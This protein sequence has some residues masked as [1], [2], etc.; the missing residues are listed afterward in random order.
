MHRYSVPGM[1][2][3]HCAGTIDQAIKAIDPRAQVTIDIKSKH[4]DVQ[5]AAGN[6][7]IINAIHSAGYGPLRW[8]VD[9]SASRFCTQ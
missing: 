4:V 8:K 6:S 5:S 2:C 9:H 1:T 7:E 3:G